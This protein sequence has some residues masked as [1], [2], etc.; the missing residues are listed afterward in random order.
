MDPVIQRVTGTR[1][2]AIGFAANRLHTAKI[3][4]VLI[5]MRQTLRAGHEV[6]ERITPSSVQSLFGVNVMEATRAGSLRC[7]A[8]LQVSS[9]SAY[10]WPWH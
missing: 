3:H 8:V 2:R 9:R 1:E 5:S 7:A 6:R 10:T 4:R